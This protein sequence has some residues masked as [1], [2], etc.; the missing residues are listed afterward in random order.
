MKRI[1]IVGGGPSGFMAAIA[2]AGDGR[3]RA[4]RA[5]GRPE[6]SDVEVVIFDRG[7]PLATL[8]RTGGGRCNLSNATYD[9]REL[10]AAYPR[11][12]KFLLS[13]YARFGAKKTMAWFEEHGLP[14]AVEGGGRVFPASRRASE[15]RDLL[16]ALARQHGVRVLAR[17]AVSRI[18]RRSGSFQLMVT[19]L[20]A[21]PPAG[22]LRTARWTAPQGPHESVEAFDAVVIATGGDSTDPEGSGYRFA[23]AFGHSITRMAPA[24]TALV[25]AEQWPS[26]VSGLTLPDARIRARFQSKTVADERGSLLFTH[27]GIS[28]PLAFRV[29][30]RC[31]FLP[32]DGRQ[33][34]ELAL[35]IFPDDGTA[36]LARRLDSALARHPR[37]SVSA[38]LR[39]LVPRS[40][41]SL[42][43]EKERILPTRQ[44]AQV[45]RDD[46]A[47]L[48]RAIGEVPLTVTA[49]QGEGEI[50]TAGGIEL[51]LV[52]QRTM[53]SRIV[54]RLFF[55]GEVLDID[56]FTGGFNLQAAWTT[57]RLAGLGAR[58]KLLRS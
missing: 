13:A 58:E 48:V 40:L 38:V 33:P 27:R 29:S 35:S 12:G 51:H 54:P 49:A 5:P 42:V 3:T 43:L 2:A 22:R 41:A 39:G 37:Q 50:V 56:G 53:E 34:L 47:A 46:R 24:L 32:Y 14:L 9:A 21:A 17:H 26:Q 30:S 52:E 57:G 8:L 18:V 31:V 23:R 25:T 28:G 6:T 44:A 4:D 11:G 20:A 1:A 15:V 16:V 7:A 55:C 10:V 36:E 19:D 45:S